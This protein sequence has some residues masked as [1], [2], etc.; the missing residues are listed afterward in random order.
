MPLWALGSS[1]KIFEFVFVFVSFI[2][3]FFETGSL[4]VALA[5]LTHRDPPTSAL[6]RLGLKA[7]M[8]HHAL[9]ILE[10]ENT[11][12]DFLLQQNE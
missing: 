11:L 2:F 8:Q 12:E 5:V 6:K 9:Q 3:F 4:C 1:Y 7:C 10:F